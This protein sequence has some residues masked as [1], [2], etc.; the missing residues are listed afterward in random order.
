MFRYLKDGYREDGDSFFTRSHTEKMRGNGYKLL[1]R[2][3]QL[4]TRGK[5]FTVRTISCWNNLTREAVD[6]PALDTFKVRLNR[7]L[8]NLV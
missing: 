2:I 4:D 8:G 1:L 6:S 5:V 3:F 7:V